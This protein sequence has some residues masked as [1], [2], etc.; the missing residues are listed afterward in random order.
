MTKEEFIAKVEADEEYAPGWDAIEEA[1]LEVYPE[2]GEEHF[3]TAIHARAMFGGDQYLDGYSVYTSP[4]G[5]KHIVSFGM[6]ELYGNPDAFGKEYNGWGYEMSIKLK[7]T[8]TKECMWAM[9]MMANLARYTFQTSR[10]FEHGQYVGSADGD[11]GAIK[12]GADSIITS[13]LLVNDTELKSRDTVYGKTEFIQLV[14][15]TTSELKAI[16]EDRSN[17]QKLIDLMKADGNE[18]LVTDLA[19]TKSYL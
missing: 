16:I 5:Y 14:G 19:R 9:D 6:T 8:D 1:M 18:D 15:I 13:L 12:Q 17:V 2:G 4:K 11:K 7:E 3:G 10:Y